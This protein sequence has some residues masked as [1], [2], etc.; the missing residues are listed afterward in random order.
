MLPDVEI[1][2]GNFQ[3][4]NWFMYHDLDENILYKVFNCENRNSS[5]LSNVFTSM[6]I[7]W[8]YTGHHNTMHIL[9][10]SI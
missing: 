8:Q 7:Y 6:V 9:I 1:S 5:V 3:R 4:K 2:E 10:L